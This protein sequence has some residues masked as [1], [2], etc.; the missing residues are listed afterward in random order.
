MNSVI[1]SLITFLCL[2]TWTLQHFQIFD[3][4]VQLDAGW[5]PLI[6]VSCLLPSL[7]RAY[8]FL[9]GSRFFGIDIRHTSLPVS[10]RGTSLYLCTEIYPY[11]LA[12]SYG[13][14]FPVIWVLAA[15]GNFVAAWRRHNTIL[16]FR[17]SASLCLYA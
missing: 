16:R 2:S 1:Q 17:S 9:L 10:K 12:N 4:Y 3:D 6:Y 5:Y 14:F 15:W 11:W 13:L 8:Q 7:F